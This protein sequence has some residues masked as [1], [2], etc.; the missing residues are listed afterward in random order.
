MLG[1]GTRLVQMRVKLIT[2]ASTSNQDIQH[3]YN[4]TEFFEIGHHEKIRNDKKI[5]KLFNKIPQND[6]YV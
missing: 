3:S 1:T 6:E 2:A 4:S 5:Q